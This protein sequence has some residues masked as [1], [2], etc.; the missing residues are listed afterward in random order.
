V[1]LELHCR[2]AGEKTEGRKRG[3]PWPRGEREEGREK[4]R[5]R[6]ESKKGKAKQ[7]LL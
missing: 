6:D 4:R 3:R 1:V 5:S 2:K 7:L